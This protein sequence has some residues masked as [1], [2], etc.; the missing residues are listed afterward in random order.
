MISAL[1]A[2]AGLAVMAAMLVVGCG[3]G[4]EEDDLQAF[5][6]ASGPGS[7]VA[8]AQSCDIPE[9]AQQMLS[10]INTARASARNCGSTAFPAAS[11][12]GWNDQLAQ[13]ASAHS[14]DMASRNFVSH[15]GS[16]G[17]SA[18]DRAQAVGYRGAVGENLAGGQTSVAQVMN[19]L[20]RSPAHCANIMNPTYKV[21]G[22]ACV[23]NRN[24][25]YKTHWTQMLG[26]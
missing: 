16:D 24:T 22:A 7:P 15:T 23:S 12:L 14:T 9:F 21:M 18:A 20:L 25:T 11:P 3:G 19:E 5:G 10:A 4:G 13:A 8:L 26:R 2:K 6:P 1:H 17:S